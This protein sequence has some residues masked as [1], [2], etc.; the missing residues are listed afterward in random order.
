MEYDYKVVDSGSMSR[1]AKINLEFCET[2]LQIGECL[3]NRANSA[4]PQ[5]VELPVFEH[6]YIHF[7]YRA[8][9]TLRAIGVLYHFRYF[10]QALILCRVQYEIL[11]HMKYIK[12]EPDKRA[13]LFKKYSEF[14]RAKLFTM[15][16]NDHSSKDKYNYT[17]LV[18]LFPDKNKWAGKNI[19][20]KKMAEEVNLIRDYELMYSILCEITHAPITLAQI[21][22]TNN[23]KDIYRPSLLGCRFFLTILIEFNDL[24]HLNENEYL[25]ELY[26]TSKVL[27]LNQQ[28]FNEHN[29]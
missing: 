9:Q 3:Y 16:G 27:F 15:N 17:E 25:D 4:F 26:N 29:K 8:L 10:E 21:I 20:L 2:C 14:S 24:F 18:K 7:L 22:A 11:V 12:N 13:D 1:E 5:N 23:E 28:E 6:S 19:T